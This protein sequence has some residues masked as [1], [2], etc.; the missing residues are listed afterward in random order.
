MLRTTT[1]FY[2]ENLCFHSY[3]SCTP[4]MAPRTHS[5]LTPNL[6]TYTSPHPST[7]PS[8]HPAPKVFAF[9]LWNVPPGGAIF[10]L[11]TPGK[12]FAIRPVHW[13][14]VWVP[15]ASSHPSH[16]C[17]G[18]FFT[19]F[20]PGASSQFRPGRSGAGQTKWPH[21]PHKRQKGPDYP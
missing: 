11:L 17:T 10:R 1:T 15:V 12:A 4:S 14:K 19:V 16:T 20:V 2:D 9:C 6:P 3:P 13:F 21:L 5:I 18:S 7:R 8:P